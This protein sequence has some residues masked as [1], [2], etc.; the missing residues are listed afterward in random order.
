VFFFVVPADVRGHW[1]FR[2]A[3]GGEGFDAQLEQAYQVLAGSAGGAA[4]TGKLAG[5]ELDFAFV[6][7]GEEVR[8]R[9]TVDGDRIAA[10]VVRAGV[11]TEYVA[12]RL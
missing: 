1:A 3:H 11:P 12:T 9:G 6:Q 5:T 7:G 4:V 8:V 2:P 10:T